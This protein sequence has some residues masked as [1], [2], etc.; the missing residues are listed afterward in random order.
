MQEAIHG[1]KDADEIDER[2]YTCKVD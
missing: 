1:L 2:G